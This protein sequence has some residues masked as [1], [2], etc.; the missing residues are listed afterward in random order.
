M[1]EQNAASG[2]GKWIVL[3]GLLALILG[4][5]FILIQAIMPSEGSIVQR[6]PA[7]RKGPPQPLSA[8]EPAS[9]DMLQRGRK[10][11]LRH[12]QLCHGPTGAGDGPG[13]RNLT[14][15]PT[16][17]IWGKFRYGNQLPDIMRTITRGSPNQRSGMIAWS[18]MPKA[19]RQALAHFV[20]A[21]SVKNAKKRRTISG[22]AR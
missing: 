22:T 18:W 15:R 19:Q 13:A 10:L 1:T 8:Y 7:F 21:L 11:Y 9:A 17:Y 3:V 5:G 14:P 4:G 12:C 16:P 20:L 2:A 6:R